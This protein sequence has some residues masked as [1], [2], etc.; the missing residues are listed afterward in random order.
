MHPAFRAFRGMLRQFADNFSWF[1]EGWRQGGSWTT[2]TEADPVPKLGHCAAKRGRLPS[3][4]F[5]ISG[6]QEKLGAMACRKDRLTKG[7]SE[8]YRRLSWSD[9]SRWL[10][11][12]TEQTPTIALAT[13]GRPHPPG[14]PPNQTWAWLLQSGWRDE[15]RIV[16]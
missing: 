7:T 4:G 12:V 8:S 14:P 2:L 3:I 5:G 13:E 16:G 11:P 10:V 15:H 6:A 9:L 1:A